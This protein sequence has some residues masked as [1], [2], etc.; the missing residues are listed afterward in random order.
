MLNILVTGSKGQLGSEIRAL[1]V[2]YQNFKFYCTN[3]EQLDISNFTAV[4]EFVKSFGINVI[5]NCAAYTAVD[6]AENESTKANEVNNLAVFNLAR[7]ANDSGISLIHIS[8]DYVYDGMAY[9]PYTED[10]DTNPKCEYG[11]SKLAGEKS[12]LELNPPNSII[13]RTSWVFSSYGSNFVKTMLRLGRERN[14][15]SII[16]DQV[17][18]PTY[19]GD[20]ARTILDILPKIKNDTVEVY[21]YSNEGVCSWFDFAK[22]IFSIENIT[23]DVS[24]IETKEYPTPAKRPHYSVLNKQKIKKAYQVEIPYW[25][26]S[27]AVCLM[28]INNPSTP[29]L[30]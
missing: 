21:H 17:G 12:M 30:I 25:K 20:L 1:K 15:L 3:Y 14:Q 22:T 27:L 23:I 18:T 8:T 13:I 2:Q 29:I 7:I 10:D 11:K 5:I 24:P 19:A 9:R 26:D 16:F 6:K 28:K 4:N